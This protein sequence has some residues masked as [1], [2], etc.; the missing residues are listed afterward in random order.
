[1]SGEPG[2]EANDRLRDDLRELVHQLLREQPPS[3]SGLTQRLREHLG[4]ADD[5][6]G[7]PVFT[8]ELSAWELPNQQRALDAIAARPGWSCTVHGLGRDARHYSGFGLGML[9]T[10]SPVSSAP[11]EYVNLPVGPGRTMPC[12]ELAVALVSAPQGAIVALIARG[13][14]DFG[15]PALTLQAAA[16]DESLAQSFLA[17]MRELR[18]QLDVYR[19]QLLTVQPQRHGG[20]SIV[21]LERPQIVRDD[22]VLPDG[23]LERIEQHIVAPTRHREALTA[24]GRHLGRGLLLWGP[25]GTGKTHTVRYLSSRLADA[26]VIVVSGGSL[27][28]VGM[29]A[30]LA[31]RLAPAVVVLEDV[32]LVAQER[33]YGPFGS[34]PVLF[35]L[36]DQMSGTGG[37]A[38]V[39]FVLTTNRPDALEPALAARPG[40][41]DLAVEIPLPDRAS[42]KRLIELYS[43]G[44]SLEQVDW[45][46]T[47][48]RTEGVTAAFIQELL[49]EALLSALED[50]RDAVSGDDVM[51]ALDELLASGATVTRTLLGSGPPG[52][53]DAVSH[54][55][56]DDDPHVWMRRFPGPAPFPGP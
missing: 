32:D 43:Q 9:L 6:S 19:G 44:M 52:R 1:M 47:L 48:D 2:D 27:E 35:E 14:H 49:R 3:D 36:M 25:P 11:P 17:E 42:R 51:V 53:S 13:E 22:L 18:D 16:A 37:D 15:A 34:N 10:R 39:A 12:L 7:V 38:D 31:R 28:S 20:A 26:T 56:D 54:D 46:Q 8:D 40:R 24:S 21:F 30:T 33:T 23:T 41:V 29:F 50:D 5:R 55:D 4:L 45:Q